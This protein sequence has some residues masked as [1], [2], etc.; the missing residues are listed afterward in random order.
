MSTGTVFNLQRYC[1]HDGPGVRTTVFLK[2]CPA[3]CWWCHNPESQSSLPEI[4]CSPNRCIACDACLLACQE[5][6]KGRDACTL[7]GSCTDACPTGAREVVGRSMTVNEVMTAVLKDRMFFES[8]GGGV[9]FSGG[10]PLCQPAFL[11]A[12]LQECRRHEIHSA[13]DTAGLCPGETLAEIAPLTDLFLFDLKCV[14]PGRHKEGTGTGNGTILENL[15]LL[16]ELQANI[17]IRI[18]VIPGFNDSTEEM[19]SIAELASWTPGVRQV[20]LLPYH[21]SW[22]SKPERF[23]REGE[24]RAQSAAPSQELLQEFARIFRA[25]GMKTE[26]GGVE[27]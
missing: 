20:W 10:E 4:A 2:G 7:C 16:S 19:R 11:K 5:G 17:W 22:S 25:N 6:L 13:V 15:K 14:D 8:S 9:T 27:K 3:A 24:S 12:L 1:L 18:P 23:G 26:I 21:A